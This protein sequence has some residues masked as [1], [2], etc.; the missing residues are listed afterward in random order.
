M[1]LLVTPN[2]SFKQFY[3]DY[4][5][6]RP[7]PKMALYRLLRDYEFKE[8]KIING[9]DHSKIIAFFLSVS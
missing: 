9:H 6:K 3:G 2:F 5:H 8:I 1:V 7:Y 4:T